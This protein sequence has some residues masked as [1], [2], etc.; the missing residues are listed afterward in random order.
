M[1]AKDFRSNVLRLVLYPLPG[2]NSHSYINRG[3]QFASKKS[4]CHLIYFRI[5]K[6]QSGVA[7]LECA[8][9]LPV[10]LVLCAG[11]LSL[12]SFFR[13]DLMLER[14]L[15]KSTLELARLEVPPIDGTPSEIRAQLCSDITSLV[16]VAIT[17][18]G[19]EAS[20]Y[21]IGFSRAELLA[22]SSHPLQEVSFEQREPAR[23]LGFQLSRHSNSAAILPFSYYLPIDCDAT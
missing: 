3:R 18:E 10:L 13:S 4:S 16:R 17:A 21:K 22:D 15:R 20:G 9:V 11:I 2:S 12:A 7:I 8:I 1:R 5:R 23:F 6:S 19:I 14:A